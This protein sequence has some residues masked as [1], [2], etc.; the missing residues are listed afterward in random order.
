MNRLRHQALYLP[1]LGFWIS[2]AIYRFFTRLG[3]TWIAWSNLDHSWS[4][5]FGMFLR[6]DLGRCAVRLVRWLDCC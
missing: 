4:E 6:T 5:M 2:L 3:L 1:V